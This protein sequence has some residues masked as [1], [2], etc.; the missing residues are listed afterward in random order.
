M[1]LLLVLAL[2]LSATVARADTLADL[3]KPTSAIA[4]C[5]N[6][7][8]PG[9]TGED[10]GPTCEGKAALAAWD[11]QARIIDA[12]RDVLV[13]ASDLPPDRT[14]SQ[15]VVDAL[16]RG[17]AAADALERLYQPG[18]DGRQDFVSVLAWM[19]PWFEY[20]NLL[21]PASIAD[22]FRILA[23]AAARPDL[24][25]PDRTALY[26]QA[27]AVSTRASELA[28][29]L[30]G[31]VG[32]QTD[33]AVY[34]VHRAALQVAASVEKGRPRPDID[35]RLASAVDSG[36]QAIALAETRWLTRSL[37]EH[38]NQGRYVART[39]RLL[40]AIPNTALSI[41]VFALLGMA[42][43]FPRMRAQHGT[44]APWKS[45][46]W[47]CSPCRAVGCWWRCR[48]RSPAGPVAGGLALCCCSG[49]SSC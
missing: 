33:A 1:R 22:G 34:A 47:S 18:P 4:G 26:G 42:L 13:R 32:R 25:A 31:D 19:R 30:G 29:E 28:A 9:G 38:P 45:P 35:A 6:H 43:L 27:A 21:R 49:C 17:A 48:G 20:Q 5:V 7:W 44:R 3:R 2:L 12:A 16:N 14:R 37:A 15:V 23:Q 36:H 24:S 46:P 39:G 11:T 40:G 41:G 8:G 10:A